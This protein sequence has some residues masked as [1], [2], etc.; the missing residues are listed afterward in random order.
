MAISPLQ[1][2]STSKTA[3]AY[4]EEELAMV[5]EFERALDAALADHFDGLMFLAQCKA[6]PKMVAEVVKRY[7]AAGWQ[8]VPDVLVP[9]QRDEAG[10]PLLGQ[11][12]VF[13]LKMSPLWAPRAE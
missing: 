13:Q 7:A 2:L 4:T 9:V 6:T 11:D 8:I 12:P 5:D 1:A 10:V 3:P